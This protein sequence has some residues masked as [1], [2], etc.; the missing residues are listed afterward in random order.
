MPHV[1]VAV[2]GAG[3]IGCLIARE[4]TRRHHDVSIAL[5]DQDMVGC[6]ASRRSAGLHIPRGGSPRIREMTRYSQ[7]YYA[8]LRLTRPTLPIQPIAM[9]VVSA[10]ETDESLR[11]S[12]LPSA[13]PTPTRTPPCS[14]TR[15]PEGVPAWSVRGAQYAD[16]PAL[17]LALARELRARV[18]VRE[19]TRVTA[20]DAGAGRGV[21]LRLADGESLTAERVVLAPGPWLAGQPWSPWV[22][23]LGIRVRKIVA[24]HLHRPPAAWDGAV[25]FQDED[26]FLLPLAGTGRWLYSYPCATWD[27]DPDTVG[28]GLT[29]D[30]ATEATESLRRTAPTLADAGGLSGRVFCDAYGPTGEPIIEVLD[31]RGRIV[32]AGAASGLGYRLAPAI[33]RA[34]TEALF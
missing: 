17:T 20:V 19:S 13:V 7:D 32:F 27:V 11:R 1:Q 15:L 34:T 4:V 14:V 29:P 18:V 16:V 6:G 24:L 33:A 28:R 2:V 10:E 31:P 21:E 8:M 25:V 9:T 30:D 22:A 12:Y 5:L 26:A 3:I 23:P